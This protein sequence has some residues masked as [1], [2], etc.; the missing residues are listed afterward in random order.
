M[1]YNVTQLT[2]R[3]WETPK[4]RKI[5]LASGLAL[6]SWATAG[7]AVDFSISLESVRIEHEAT[8]V[9]TGA[10]ITGGG[11]YNQNQGWLITGG[12]HAVDNKAAANPLIAG[13]G[14]KAYWFDLVDGA[15]GAALAPGFFVRYQPAFAQGFGAEAIAHYAPPILTFSEYDHFAELHV[16][17]SYRVLPQARAFL[18]AVYSAAAVSGQRPDAVDDGLYLGFRVNY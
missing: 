12:F 17:G 14:G 16:R 4:M 15:A 7:G 18:G 8:R 6:A 5:L 3:C 2:I 13:L 10:L 9:G 11:A 1:L